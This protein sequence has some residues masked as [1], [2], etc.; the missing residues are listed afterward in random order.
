MYVVFDV[1]GPKAEVDRILQ[2]V[3]D[4]RV[5]VV[6]RQSLLFR[7][8][9]A[10]GFPAYGTFVVVEGTEAGLAAAEALFKDIG[11][12]LDAKNAEA[13]YRAIRAQEDDAASG[14]GLIFG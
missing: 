9:K 14:M 2:D 1:K 10:L 3:Q 11:K 5:D 8:A 12:K 6:S 7:D 4:P 13:V